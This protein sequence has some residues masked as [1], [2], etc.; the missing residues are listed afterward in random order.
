MCKEDPVFC[1]G[2]CEHFLVGAPLKAQLA[3]V[4]RVP[5]LTSENLGHTSTKTLVDQEPGLPSEIL[6]E[7][8]HLSRRCIRYTSP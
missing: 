6:D 2:T 4:A 3:N 7:R 1:P 5:S 8:F